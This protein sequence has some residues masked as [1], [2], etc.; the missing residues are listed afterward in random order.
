MQS[1]CEYEKKMK[2]SSFQSKYCWAM[3]YE[4][5]PWLEIKNIFVVNTFCVT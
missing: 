5:K 1:R 4:A 3:D 2:A